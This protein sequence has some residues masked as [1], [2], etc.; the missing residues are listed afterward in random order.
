MIPILNAEQIRNADSAT[1]VNEPISAIDLMERAS[2]V[3]VARCCE[4]LKPGDRIKT[5]CGIGNNG[6][7]GLAISRM[8]LEK[9]FFVEVFVIGDLDRATD[10]FKSNFFIINEIKKCRILNSESDFP[11]LKKEDLLIDAIFGSGL[12]RIVTGLHGS[13]FEVMNQSRAKIISVDIASGLFVDKV[14]PSSPAIR[15]FAT[16]SFQ[17]PKLAFLMPSLSEFVGIWTIEDIGLN[18]DFVMKCETDFYFTE[19]K[20]IISILKPL[21]KF[22]HKG[23]SGRLQLVVGSQGKIGAAVLCA[24]AAMRT[25]VGLLSVHS[26][27]CGLD[28]LQMSVPEAMVST[29]DNYEHITSVNQSFEAHAIGLGPGIGTEQTTVKAI[30]KLLETTDLPMVFDA[31]AINILAKYDH[32]LKLIPK[33]SILTPH[34]GEFKR[35]VGDWETDLQKLDLLKNFSKK[36]K[37]NVVLKGAFSAVCDCSGKIYFNPTGN[38]GM[39]TAGSGDVLTGI[40]S[41]FLAQGYTSIDALRM[42]V[43]IHGLAGDLSRDKFGER[44]LIASD[45]IDAI[46]LALM[47][48]ESQ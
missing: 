3:F 5:F 7:D 15:P 29:D 46:P 31:D 9:G 16:I 21:H 40:V 42:G 12:S 30:H 1:M 32:L 47:S 11:E 38:S 25:G 20:D 37:V 44:S 19:L 13:L 41:S 45:I 2:S 14:L 10:D 36:H 28:I 48:L 8:L 6:G 27:L 18:E 22:A 35:L 17:T 4:Y 39:A 33:H 34:P 26:P 24:K 23:E 43:Y